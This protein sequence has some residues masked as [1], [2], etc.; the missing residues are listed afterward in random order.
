M[1]GISGAW[2]R[3]IERW[4]GE[5]R[6][7]IFWYGFS[8]T[9]AWLTVLA[10]EILHG[11]YAAEGSFT[12]SSLP[13]SWLFCDLQITSRKGRKQ[14]NFY[15]VFFPDKSMENSLFLSKNSDCNHLGCPFKMVVWI[16]IPF[17]WALNMLP[18][19]ILYLI[20]NY[21]W[22]SASPHLFLLC[23]KWSHPVIQLSVV[24]SNN[25]RHKNI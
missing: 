19:L 21:I 1:R 3:M 24:F 25:I 14:F 23:L 16:Q 11:V 9:P 8:S 20:L 5:E 2:E 4:R 13:C 6:I 7:L 18:F 10:T 17:I 22:W 12:T 15:V